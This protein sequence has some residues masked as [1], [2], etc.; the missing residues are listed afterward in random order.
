MPFK[1]GLTVVPFKA[2]LTVY[3]L[4]LIKYKPKVVSKNGVEQMHVQTYKLILKRCGCIHM[5]IFVIFSMWHKPKINTL[6]N[7]KSNSYGFLSE[8]DS[9]KFK[10]TWFVIRTSLFRWSTLG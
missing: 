7:R 9:A 2:G 4:L 5:Y 8:S 10:R 3:N 6:I 1:A